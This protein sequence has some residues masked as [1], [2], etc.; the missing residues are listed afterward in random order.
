MPPLPALGM[1]GCL[2]K[3]GEGVGQ[4]GFPLCSPKPREVQKAGDASQCCQEDSK[5]GG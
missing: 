3:I 4:R 5:R 1:P 2:D